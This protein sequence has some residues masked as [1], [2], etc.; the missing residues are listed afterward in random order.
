MVVKYVLQERDDESVARHN[1]KAEV[2]DI[3][4]ENNRLSTYLI[5]LVEYWDDAIESTLFTLGE[6]RY[7]SE[8]EM[9]H[10]GDVI[11]DEFEVEKTIFEWV[12]MDHPVIGFSHADLAGYITPIGLLGFSHRGINRDQDHRE[13]SW[14]GK[15]VDGTEAMRQFMNAGAVRI[16]GTSGSMSVRRIPTKSVIDIMGKIAVKAGRFDLDVI[17]PAKSNHLENDDT[18]SI[19]GESFE[20]DQA[21]F[22]MR[23][24]LRQADLS[25]A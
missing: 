3:L 11:K 9:C 2:L 16:A 21:I 23:N 25:L 17:R 13:I 12:A 14:P 7:L 24:F 4:D 8:I 22:R 18:L 6:K 15:S 1:A 5:D 20:F 19:S 10:E